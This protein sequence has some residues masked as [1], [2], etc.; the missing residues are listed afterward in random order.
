MGVEVSSEDQVKAIKIF[1][2]H[3]DTEIFSRS[4]IFSNEYALETPK[5]GLCYRQIFYS[6]LGLCIIMHCSTL[7]VYMYIH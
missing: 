6:W 3:V 2:P 5:S 1:N 4:W 7:L